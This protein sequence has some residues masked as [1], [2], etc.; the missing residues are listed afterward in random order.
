MNK[1]AFPVA[2]LALGLVACQS[3][4]T[5]GVLHASGHIEVTQVR[6]ASPLGGI[7]QE[8][9]FQ[10][11]QKV[12]AGQ[13]VA[14][15]D[16]S[17]LQRELEKAQAERDVAQAALASLLAGARKEEI[18]EARAK[19]A[20]AEAEMA[21]AQAD[22]QRYEP[23][24]ER[25]STSRKLRDDAATRL[26]VAQEQRNALQARLQLLLAGPRQ[27]EVAAARARL[28]A[29]EAAVRVFRQRLAD[30][31]VRAPIS[32]FITSRVAEP[33]EYLP[34]GA[35]IAVLADL[36]HPWL[37]VYVDE[38]SLSAVR[39]GQKVLVRTDGAPQ[40]V[41]GTVSFVAQEAEFTPKNVQTPEERAK[42]VFKVKVALANP[43]YLF[44]PGMPAD[45]FFALEP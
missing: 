31:E 17:L 13:V 18:A 12:E 36:D 10:E 19:L 25:G 16:T 39:L 20:A 21:A 42:L 22:L 9:P 28:Q 44:K 41:A 32:G 4:S 23:L 8:A 2:F 7:L 6:L 15:L 29:A 43:N 37:T 35:T 1:K 34:P 30:A 24:A 26:A 40:G 27:E 33:G 5:P 3:R 38:A 11:G 45:A 14:R